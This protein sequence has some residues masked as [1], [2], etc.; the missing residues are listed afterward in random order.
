MQLARTTGLHC[1]PCHLDNY[2][3]VLLISPWRDFRDTWSV[4]AKT[5]YVPRYAII[6]K[7][8]LP[9]L[10]LLKEAVQRESLLEWTS[11]RRHV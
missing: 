8:E 10:R 7:S 4:D 2:R 9:E 11:L 3:D 1:R 6:K 5:F